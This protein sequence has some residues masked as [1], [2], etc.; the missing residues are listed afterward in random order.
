[1]EMCIKSLEKSLEKSS[2]NVENLQRS[3]TLLHTTTH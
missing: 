3:F 2:K 1:M